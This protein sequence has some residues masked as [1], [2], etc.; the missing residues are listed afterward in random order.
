MSHNYSYIT[1]QQAVTSLY[2]EK[3]SKFLGFAFPVEDEKDI[4]EQLLYL[5]ELHPKA[6]HHCYAWRLDED[7]FRS[8]DDGEP[9]GTAG[10]PILGQIDRLNI[11]K[12][13]VVSVRYFGGTKLGVSGLITAYKASAR[14]TLEQ[15]NIIEKELYSEFELQC[16]Y[17]SINLAY[18]WIQQFEAEII[19]QEMT[20]SCRFDVKIPLRLQETAIQ[21]QEAFYP[22]AFKL[23][24]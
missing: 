19:E 21:Q 3:G 24:T 20:D 16:D 23:I 7:N 17:N 1:I 12:C 10:R 22:V 11:T 15:A 8:D 6:T 9:T 4:Q 5:R 2:K 18:Q 13:L 14:E